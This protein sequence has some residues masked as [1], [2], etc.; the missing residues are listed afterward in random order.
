M[1]TG[2]SIQGLSSNTNS[3]K[4]I[5]PLAHPVQVQEVRAFEQCPAE[6]LEPTMTGTATTKRILTLIQAATSSKPRVFEKEIPLQPLKTIRV[7][8]VVEAIPISEA[9]SFERATQF[10]EH[11][12]AQAKSLQVAVA[13]KV[14]GIQEVRAFEKT[15]PAEGRPLETGRASISRVLTPM[16]VVSSTEILVL[17]KESTIEPLIVNR[18]SG[19]YQVV[20]LAQVVPME[21]A[22][23]FHTEQ[24]TLGRAKVVMPLK[25]SI[26]V[27]ETRPFE[28]AAVTEQPILEPRRASV[29]QVLTPI[30][31]ASV[32]QA[33]VFEKESIFGSISTSSM[34][35]VVHV[36]PTCQAISFEKA[37]L[38]EQMKT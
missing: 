10:Q 25:T 12:S 31:A 4:R 35:P 24:P 21:Q 32:E 13:R 37:T 38:F 27:M 30:M 1:G 5:V 29:K 34:A 8:P 36:T 18:A 7:T 16:K 20:S 23:A 15:C 28:T 33:H 3:S 26:E 11:P 2:F 6:K 9:T 19:S 17:S 14:A 22:T